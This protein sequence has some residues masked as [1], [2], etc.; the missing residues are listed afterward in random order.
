[1]SV[2]PVVVDIGGEGRYPL[3]WNV[4]PRERRTC[5]AQKGQPIPRRIPGRGDAVPLADHQAD[6]IIVERA[7]LSRK[8]IEEIRRITRRGAIVV[9]R[10]PVVFGFDP[11]GLAKQ[12]LF[13]NWRERQCWVASIR[14]KET[15]IE[16]ADGIE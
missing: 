10:H 7:P 13:G 15:V 6:V 12:L 2:Q 4:N 9:L 1:M 5:G 11:H 3:A 8:A 14:C 16:L